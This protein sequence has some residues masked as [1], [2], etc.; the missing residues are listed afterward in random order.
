MPDFP[1]RKD[2]CSM[3]MMSKGRSASLIINV[4]RKP[5]RLHCLVVDYSKK[6]FRLRGSFQLIKHGQVVELMFDE[7]RPP[8]PVRYRVA[9]VGKSGSKQEG[10]VGLE[11]V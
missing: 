4:G 3:R 6:G 11:T 7:D 10:Q 1:V 8:N 2:R 9:W 5:K